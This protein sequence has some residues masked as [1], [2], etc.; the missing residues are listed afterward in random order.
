MMLETDDFEKVRARQGKGE[1][2]CPKSLEET[3]VP[4][5][6]QSWQEWTA[7]LSASQFYPVKPPKRKSQHG[8]NPTYESSL[9]PS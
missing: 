6:G 7:D 2:R 8:P 9:L 4:H 3:R 1:L 5:C